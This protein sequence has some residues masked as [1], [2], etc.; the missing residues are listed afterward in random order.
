MFYPVK[1]D[2]VILHINMYSIY[3]HI[4]QYTFVCRVL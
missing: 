1:A 3:S 2:F 4:F